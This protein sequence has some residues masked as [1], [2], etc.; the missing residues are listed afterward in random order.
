MVDLLVELFL[1]KSQDAS[2]CEKKI[3][4]GGIILPKIWNFEQSKK[5]RTQNMIF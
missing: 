3:S 4:Q 5:T 1:T 2:S